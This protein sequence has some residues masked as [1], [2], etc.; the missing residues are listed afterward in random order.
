MNKTLLA[1]AFAFAA[2]APALAETIGTITASIDGGEER[3]F[4]AIAE[5]GESQS[6]WTQI[7]PGSL[8]GSSFSI[9]GNPGQGENATSDVLI[10]AAT[11]MRGPGGYIAIADAQ[12]LENYFS[13]YWMAPEGDSVQMTLSRVEENGDTLIVEG[14]FNAP[15]FY[16]EGAAEQKTDMNRKMTISG[17][18]SVN[19]PKQ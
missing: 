18:F 17:S 9:W 13:K 2:A 6:F 10:V 14:K 16:T 11:L 4:H 8:S 3:S 5:D 7:M 12:Y 15:L 19:L 1:I